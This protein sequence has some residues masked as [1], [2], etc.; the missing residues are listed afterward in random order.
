MYTT[1]LDPRITSAYI[2]GAINTFHDS[3][4]TIKHCVCNYVPHL[5]EYAE[6]PDVA[7][8]IAPRPLMVEN[9]DK[10]PI[11]PDFGV[12]KAVET[13]QKVYSA[14][15]HPER[16]MTHTFQGMHRWDGEPIAEWLGKQYLV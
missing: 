3:I 9:G 4:M 6:K 1:A 2:S 10:D 14:V 11:Y 5:L 13:L 7:G 8:L 12:K 15:G 16:L